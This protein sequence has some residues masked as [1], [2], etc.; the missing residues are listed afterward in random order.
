MSKQMSFVAL[1]LAAFLVSAACNG[2]S[3]A[4]TKAETAPQA[5]SMETLYTENGYPVSVRKLAAESF[6]VYLKYPTVLQAQSESTAYAALSDVVRKINVKVGDRVERDQI[7]LSFSADNQTL[8]QARLS[9]ENAELSYKRS[10]ALFAAAD[11]SRQEFDAERT[12][13]EIARSAF[14]AASDMINVK[15]PIT[16][17][18]TKLNVHTTENVQ[19]GTPLF[20]VT[21]ASGF[22]TRFYVGANEIDRVQT[23]IPVYVGDPKRNIEGRISQISLV[24]DGAKQAFPVTA[25]FDVNCRDLVSGMGVDVA[26]ETYRNDKALV[27]SRRELVKTNKGH[28]AFIVEDGRAKQIA[29]ELGEENGL[30][31]EIVAG[32]N[33]GDMLIYEGQQRLAGDVRLNV[34]TRLADA[35]RR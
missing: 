24:M 23:G 14:K 7:I 29:V 33:E 10:S 16:G 13:C 15:S 9:C 8:E 6:P 11:I 32:L 3:G 31:Y 17:T 21:G 22:E 12:R 25:F 30:R 35:G 5:V 1:A 2:E 4:V 19:P 26:V 20:T 27:L 18:I 34:V 28:T